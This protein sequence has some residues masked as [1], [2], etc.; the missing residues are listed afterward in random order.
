M[1]QRATI[2]F[3]AAMVMGPMTTVALSLPFLVK[4]DFCL[5]RMNVSGP[6][7]FAALTFVSQRLNLVSLCFYKMPLIPTY[8]LTHH[9]LLA[10]NRIKQF[11][12]FY[13]HRDWPAD[14]FGTLGH[15]ARWIVWNDSYRNWF[16][17]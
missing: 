13:T 5:L 16:A 9:Y 8:E 3:N 17:P 2:G 1:P 12:W 6:A 11:G 15:G 7:L 4:I 10:R 14:G